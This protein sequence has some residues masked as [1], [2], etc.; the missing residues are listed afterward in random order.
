MSDKKIRKAADIPECLLPSLVDIRLLKAQD[1]ETHR[2]DVEWLEKY[3]FYVDARGYIAIR[4]NATK[5]WQAFK[6]DSE[7]V[8]G[9]EMPSNP[10][11]YVDVL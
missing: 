9:K 6:A 11:G 3:V 2:L 1:D 7:V 4:P 8:K 5:N 10:V